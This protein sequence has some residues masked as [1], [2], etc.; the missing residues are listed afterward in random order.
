MRDMIELHPIG[1]VR[2]ERSDAIDDDWDR[3]SV[4]IE[5]DAAYAPEALDGIEA[6]SH[7]EVL[8][9]FDR[10]APDAVE[11]G[12]RHP[13]GNTAW[14]KVGVF[15]QRGKNRPNRLGATVVRVLGRDGRVLRVAGLDAIDGTP[16]VDIK[17]VMREFLPRGDVTQPAWATELMRHYWRQGDDGP[18]TAAASPRRIALVTLVVREYDEAVAFFTGTLGFELREDTDLGGGKRWVRVAPPGGSGAELL[19]ARA[20]SPEQAARVGDQTGGRVALFL[21]TSDFDRD[22]RALG[23]AGVRF[24]GAPRAETYGKV[25]VFVDPYG[26]RWDLVE[27]RAAPRAP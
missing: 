12:A 17:P 9:V 23:A 26:N 25:V 2:S 3:V 8:Y 15:A 20:A 21:E 18:G 7:A 10:V 5:L 4:R 11:R 6:F 19:L 22:V 1:V 24:E 13:R 14:P 27:R 16:V